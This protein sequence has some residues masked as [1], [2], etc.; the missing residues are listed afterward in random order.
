MGAATM[1]AKS[2]DS[3]PADLHTSRCAA[4]ERARPRAGVAA[5][6]SHRYPLDMAQAR[7][8]RETLLAW[9]LTPLFLFA[10]GAGITRTPLLWAPISYESDPDG[11]TG[12]MSAFDTARKLYAPRDRPGEVALLFGNSRMAFAGDDVVR[13]SIRKRAPQRDAGSINLSVFGIGPI[14]MEIVARHAPQ[15]SPAL[16]VIGLSPSDL[17]IPVPGDDHAIRVLEKGWAGGPASSQ[18]LADRADRALRGAWPL[19]RFREFAKMALIDRVMRKGSGRLPPTHFETRLEFFEY[20]RPGLGGS[21]EEAYQA[22]R[23]SPGLQSYLAYL[24]VG[25]PDLLTAIRSRV[26]APIDSEAL[27]LQV[28]ALDRMLV[29]FS[30]A[31]VPALIVLMPENPLLSLP[32]AERFRDAKRE[33]LGMQEILAAA[34]AR[35][36]EV[37]DARRWFELESFLDLDHIFPQTG[38]L[39]ERL[40]EVMLDAPDA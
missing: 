26:E 11:R 8:R 34:R 6:N 10:L 31:D 35:G 18:E 19:Y 37:V 28:A 14:G 9:L 20:M 29:R 24:R 40:A 5:A 25:Q 1:A 36:V 21:M 38:G 13:D 39:E 7:S 22:F 30:D 15:V 27:Q 16:S 2:A 17:F 32:Q 3:I 23:R 12:F 4:E 33:E